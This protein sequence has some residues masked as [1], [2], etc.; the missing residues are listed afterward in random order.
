VLS[1]S[2]GKQTS[3]IPH[4]T[5]YLNYF[6]KEKKKALLPAQTIPITR[7]EDAKENFP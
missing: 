7:K 1:K 3:E 4:E 2:S 6:L 5:V